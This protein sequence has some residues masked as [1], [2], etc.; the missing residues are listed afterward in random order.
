MIDGDRL[1][2]RWMNRLP[3]R[4]ADGSYYEAPGVSILYYAGHGRFRYEED[5]LNMVHVAEVIQESGWQP[6]AGFRRPPRA[7]RR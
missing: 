6:G 3:G 7:P 2:T 4:R 1:V 5:L